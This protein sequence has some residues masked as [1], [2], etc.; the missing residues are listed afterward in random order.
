M[1]IFWN[2]ISVFCIQ[3]HWKASLTVPRLAPK[4]GMEVIFHKKIHCIGTFCRNE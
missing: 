2:F 3:P 1:A 4:W